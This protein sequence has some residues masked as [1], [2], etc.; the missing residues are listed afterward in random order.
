MKLCSKNCSIYHTKKCIKCNDLVKAAHVILEN[1]ICSLSSVF[2]NVFPGIN[3]STQHARSRL[4]QLPVAAIRIGEP[5]SG[6]S[7]IQV[8]E[9]IPGLDYRKFQKLMELFLQQSGRQT[10][11]SKDS[12]HQLLSFAQGRRERETLT[13]AVYRASGISVTAAQ[14]HLQM[15]FIE[16]PHSHPSHTL[17]QLPS[18]DNVL[19]TL[20]ESRWNWFH[21]VEQMEKLSP[22]SE[23][24]DYGVL[25]DRLEQVYDEVISSDRLQLDAQILVKQWHDAY[26]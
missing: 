14:K 12:F 25:D 16:D 20:S 22:G 9:V 19:S 17:L 1:G 10:L 23:G 5:S 4:L 6:S 13:Y 2:R 15:L 11:M 3:Y 18:M 26:V 24:E 7:E 8:M 21:F